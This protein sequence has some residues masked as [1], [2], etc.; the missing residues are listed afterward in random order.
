MSNFNFSR[1][2]EAAVDSFGRQRISPIQTVFESEQL[3]DKMP[4]FWDELLQDGGG[5]PTSVYQSGDAA[6]K[7][8]VNSIGDSVYRQ[9]F[10]RF[11]YQAGKSTLIL[12]TG[13]MGSV[14][15]TTRRIGQFDGSGSSGDNGFFFEDDGT[16]L[17]IVVEK[18]GTRAHE[19]NQS[20]WNI[21]GMGHGS[22]AKNPSGITLDI[23]KTLIFVI[24]Y[25]WLGVGRVRFGF[26][27]A[28]GIH[29][30]HECLN[31]NLRTTVY[32]STPNLPIRYSI[33]S[34]GGSGSLDHICASVSQEGGSDPVGPTRTVDRG[35]NPLTNVDTANK[36]A[37]IGYRQ[38]SGRPGAVLVPRAID[39]LSRTND[40]FHWELHLNP[41]LN[42]QT[43]IVSTQLTK[44]SIEKRVPP[45][46]STVQVS[47]DGVV[48]AS[49]YVAQQV[50]T[51]RSDD[52]RTAIWPGLSLADVRDEIWLTVQP[53][54]DNLI[55]M[56]AIGIREI[57]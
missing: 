24:D 35:I 29:Y 6:T 19:V 14:A 57:G 33:I 42:T 7:M 18:D 9:T 55:V 10:M 30:V 51:L 15:N 52:L 22:N 1:V 38:V 39:F 56:G 25:E 16:N 36:Y 17:K 12:M 53:L 50:R 41:V 45:T 48:L 47:T 46:N 49:G 40:S 28:G 31:S 11:P 43:G 13:V 2:S 5:T 8:T 32:T 4:I 27:I 34:S 3:Y 26:G 44:S 21:D 23:T 54:S 20:A 37:V